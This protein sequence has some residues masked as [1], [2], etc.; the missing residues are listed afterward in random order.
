MSSGGGSTSTT[1][2]GPPPEFTQ[3]WLENYQ[4]TQ[5][6]VPNLGPEPVMGPTPDHYA[7]RQAIYNTQSGPGMYN[8]G[9]AAQ[10][11]GDMAQMAPYMITP[12]TIPDFDRSLYMNPYTSEVIDRTM[13]D[14]NRQRSISLQGIGDQAQSAGAFG[15]SRH[16]VADAET[17]RAYADVMARTSAQ[18]RDQGFNQ[19]SGLMVGDA[20][21]LLQGQ[22]A[23]ANLGL[24]STGLLGG[25]ARQ[26][27]DQEMRSA[28]A[29]MGL[30]DIFGGYPQQ[31]ASNWWELPQIQQGLLNQ[32]LGLMQG[33]NNTNSRTK[34]S[35]NYLGSAAMLGAAAMPYMAPA[36]AGGATAASVGT[37]SMLPFAFNSDRRLKE[38]IKPIRDS[39]DVIRN[40]NGYY[41]NF[42]GESIPT[43]GVMAQELQKVLPEAVLAHP[44]GSLMVNYAAVTAV[45]VDAV[46]KLLDRIEALES[47]REEH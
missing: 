5:G 43:G 42:K 33:A 30:G 8:T 16:G 24:A 37:P 4:R 2:S 26:Q 12:Y 44:S 13:D 10:M 40:L 18:L 47:K 15:G 7:G 29:M 20:D 21:R 25:L 31:A 38:N 32:S 19:A 45:L 28:L 3:A 14:M 41:Y 46:G 39:V 6:W 34:E 17:Q 1:T 36:L 11:A 22:T 9:L 23:S 27:Y 35:P